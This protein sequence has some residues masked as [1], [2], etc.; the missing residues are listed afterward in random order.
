MYTLFKRTH[1][2]KLTHM[3][4]YDGQRRHAVEIRCRRRRRRMK[5]KVKIHVLV[6]VAGVPEFDAA[7]SPYRDHHH[8]YVLR[9]YVCVSVVIWC[10]LVKMRNLQY[11][12]ENSQPPHA[13]DHICH[14][15]PVILPSA[16]SV[17]YIEKGLTNNPGRGRNG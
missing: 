4:R 9:I 10:G 17:G 6:V 3:H 15:Q 16:T 7:V 14:T 11:L 2:H 1:A 5:K 12:V 13:Y 8:S